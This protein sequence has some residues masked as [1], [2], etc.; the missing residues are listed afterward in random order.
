MCRWSNDSKS[1]GHKKKD[2]TCMS[3]WGA[4]FEGLLAGHLNVEDPI[5]IR[6]FADPTVEAL[7]GK[8][9]NG[10]C[11]IDVVL[12][13]NRLHIKNLTAHESPLVCSTL[14][15]LGSLPATDVI[16]VA[17]FLWMLEKA[18]RRCAWLINQ[19]V[20]HV[21][22]IIEGSVLEACLASQDAAAGGDDDIEGMECADMLMSGGALPV[23]TC[24]AMQCKQANASQCNAKQ[25]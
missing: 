15:V 22:T 6:L 11:P 16:T 2:A 24:K 1:Q 23:H 25:C 8:P 5:A 14:A 12:L 20:W 7:P 17:C 21:S 13:H 4:C 9:M 19:V 10:P 3:S 18:G